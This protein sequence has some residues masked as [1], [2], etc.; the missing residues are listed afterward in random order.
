MAL[1]WPFHKIYEGSLQFHLTLLIEMSI[2][3]TK[4]HDQGYSS[5]IHILP[6]VILITIASTLVRGSDGIRTWLNKW[7]RSC[8]FLNNR[9]FP[10]SPGEARRASGAGVM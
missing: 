7:Q 3:H 9:W 1:P 6:E 8:L 2:W 4:L 10:A 5:R